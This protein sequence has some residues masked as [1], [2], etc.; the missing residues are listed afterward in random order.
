MT[1]RTL[2]FLAGAA[3]L[4]L[5]ALVSMGSVLVA[6]IGMWLARVVQRAR[7]RSN[8]RATS[9]MGAVLACALVFGGALTWAFVRLPDGFVEQ[10]Q[11][12]TSERQREPTVIERVVERATPRSPA[13]A[14]MEKKTQELAHSKAFIW[15]VT[16]VGGV[17]SAGMA[18]LLIGSVGWA[19]TALMF[20]GVT[21]RAPGSMG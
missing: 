8:T 13:Q 2:S 20:F 5:T 16:I 18:A 14:A 19:G 1:S 17:M 4:A 9:W 10:V 11:Q 3:L 7:G 12:K 15:W 6:P 21:G